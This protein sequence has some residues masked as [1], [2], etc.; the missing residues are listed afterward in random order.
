MGDFKAAFERV[1]VMKNRKIGE[2]STSNQ[3]RSQ[4]STRRALVPGHGTSTF[5]VEI[6]KDTLK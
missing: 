6:I 5:A 1:V 2:K 4:F 3:T